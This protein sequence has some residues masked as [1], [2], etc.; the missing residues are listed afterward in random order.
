[1]IKEEI[2]KRQLSNPK[3]RKFAFQSMVEMFQ[4]RLYHFARK[5]VLNHEDANDVI[6]ES[7]L[8][9]WKSL[10]K[11]R[12]ES[13]LYTWLY[14][15]VVNESLSVL[16]RNKRQFRLLASDAEDYRIEQLKSDPYFCGGELELKLQ[17]AIL[18]LPEKQRLVFNMKYFDEM[19]YEQMSEILD[20][21]VGALKASYFHAKKKIE[22]EMLRLM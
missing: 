21:S 10:D 1:M 8:K 11:F 14:R 15:I 2:I 5:M 17:R 9:A 16:E 7:F 3:Q 4:E 6:Q 20:T 13:S 22:E 19:K 12:G 18:K